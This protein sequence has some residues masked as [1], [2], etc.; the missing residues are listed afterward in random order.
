MKEAGSKPDDGEKL[1]LKEVVAMGIGGM[2]GG[3]IFSVLGLAIAQAGH[4]A[5]I[6]FAIGGII[7]LITGLSYAHLGL[8][9]QSS[10]GSFT[11]LEHAFK[12]RNIAAMG[13]WLLL[14][15]YVGTMALYAYLWNNNA[16]NLLWIGI[17][18]LS[19]IIT[20]LLFSQRRLLLK[21]H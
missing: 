3:G 2:V 7:A 21:T 11:F 13:G 19:V 5:P 14:V 4:A 9:F 8:A 20:E 18:Y 1:T 10:G 15:G 16:S 6:A 17:I 12:N